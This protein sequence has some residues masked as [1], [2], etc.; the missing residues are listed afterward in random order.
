MPSVIVG[1][2][3]RRG[4]GFCFGGGSFI[5]QGTCCKTWKLGCGGGEGSQIKEPDKK[6]KGKGGEYGDQSTTGGGHEKQEQRFKH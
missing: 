1:L 2:L 5:N 4:K 6:K 3:I